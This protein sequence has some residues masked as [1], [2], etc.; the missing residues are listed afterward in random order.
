[1]KLPFEQILGKE[2][3]LFDGAMGTL[4]Q[5]QGLQ[6]GAL[7]E[8]WNLE[9]P[10]VI[11]AVHR[12]YAKSGARVHKSNTFGCNT[13]K[14]PAE[15]P[16]EEIV[17]AGIANAKYG[18]GKNGYVALDLGPTGK[19]PKPLGPLTTQSIAD[20]YTPALRA[21]VAA[22]ADFVLF[23]TFSDLYEAKCAL[24]CAKEIC[25]LPVCISF[26]F[27]ENGRLLDGATPECC[28]VLAQSLGSAQS[29]C[30]RFCKGCENI[31][32]CRFSAMQTPGF[33]P[34]KTDSFAIMFAL[35]NLRKK[36]VRF[37]AQAWFYSAAAAA[38]TPIISARCIP[39]SQKP[40][41]PKSSEK[42]R[43]F[44]SARA[45]KRCGFAVKR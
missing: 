11:R 28:A 1:M 4:L 2:L 5:K 40:P 44:A 12:A 3:L 39:C 42:S 10:Q 16:L 17:R 32:L 7:A 34:R 15:Q 22:G 30:C 18:A 37:C 45:K 43:P 23:E 38:P 8:L 13:V 14:F 24:L 36:A 6:G 21:G 25:A 31:P 19:L 29:R 9:K 41:C 26:T 35:P 33:P 20:A 27:G